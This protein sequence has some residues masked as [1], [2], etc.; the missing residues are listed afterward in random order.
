MSPNEG[1]RKLYARSVEFEYILR[2]SAKGP[3]TS[4]TPSNLVSG[5]RSLADLLNGICDGD[6][7]IR[8]EDTEVYYRQENYEAYVMIRTNKDMEDVLKQFFTYASKR[9]RVWRASDEAT[10]AL[11]ERMIRDD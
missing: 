2:F 8:D 6:D 3:R 7:S 11:A 10:R 9:C 4:S 5:P 1:G